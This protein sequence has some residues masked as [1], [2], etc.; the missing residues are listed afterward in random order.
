MQK[1]IRAPIGFI[2]WHMVRT[3]R[4]ASRMQLVIQSDRMHVLPRFI[5]VLVL[6]GTMAQAADKAPSTRF[7]KS[8]PQQDAA[9]VAQARKVCAD[10]QLQLKI[11]LAEFQTAHFI[12][13]TDWDPR[14]FAFLKTNLESA[15]SAV[16]RHFEIGTKENI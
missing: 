8:T 10:V 15:Y 3:I 6:A 11:K 2:G 12:V 16:A 4:R 1:A 7:A 5:A 14:E 9:A 13:F